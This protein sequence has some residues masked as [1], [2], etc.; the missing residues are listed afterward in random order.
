MISPVEQPRSSLQGPSAGALVHISKQNFCWSYKLGGSCPRQKQN[1]IWF[2]KFQ[3]VIIYSDRFLVVRS[4]TALAIF[5]YDPLPP[6]GRPESLG[7]PAGATLAGGGRGEDKISSLHRS[8][9]VVATTSTWLVLDHDREESH[10]PRE[11]VWF[12]GMSACMALLP[13]LEPRQ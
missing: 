8:Y 2:A 13:L 1:L 3:S 7:V 10:G 11:S 5:Q 4:L 6:P 12:S 9:L